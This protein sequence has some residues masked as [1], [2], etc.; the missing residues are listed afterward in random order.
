MWIAPFTQHLLKAYMIPKAFLILGIGTIV[1][2]CLL[3][4]LLANP[5]VGYTPAPGGGARDRPRQRPWRRGPT[6]IGMRC[7]GRG[8]STSSG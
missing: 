5:P 1:L 8:S 7:C 2:V 3:S 6:W 4:Q